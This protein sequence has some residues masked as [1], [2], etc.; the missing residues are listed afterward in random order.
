MG[1]W[2]DDQEAYI[3][4]LDL[5]ACGTEPLYTDTANLL[6]VVV[7]QKKQLLLKD[8]KVQL[9][10]DRLV[11]EGDGRTM[12]LPFPE[13]RAMACIAGHKLN[14]F[15]NDKVYQLQGGR[16]FN[17]LKYCNLYYRAKFIQEGHA[18]GEFQFL[19]L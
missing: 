8:A 17:A 9:C 10:A 13:I 14:I 11:I 7:Y 1:D 3:R 2:Y 5:S 16:S 12:E 19:G 15:H 6:E 4:A 18:D